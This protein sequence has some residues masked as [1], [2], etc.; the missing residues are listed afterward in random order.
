MS[1]SRV[2]WEAISSSARCFDGVRPIR[3]SDNSRHC[4]AHLISVPLLSAAG[5]PVVFGSCIH[6]MR[7]NGTFV[8]TTSMAA[9][10]IVPGAKEP[11]MLEASRRYAEPRAFGKPSRTSGDASLQIAFA[12]RPLVGLADWSYKS[13]ANPHAVCR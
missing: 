1:P 7:A 9:T 8:T 3:H 11:G 5:F 4:R 12:L 13:R 6:F 2:E 10:M